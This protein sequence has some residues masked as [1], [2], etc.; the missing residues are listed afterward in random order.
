M[1]P[2][3]SRRISYSKKEM[4]DKR[5]QTHLGTA[6]L[7]YERKFVTP[8]FPG[9]VSQKTINDQD[10]FLDKL[11]SDT[12]QMG[13][14]QQKGTKDWQAIADHTSAMVAK[15]CKSITNKQRQNYLLFQGFINAMKSGKLEG[16]MEKDQIN[17]IIK[18]FGFF[19]QV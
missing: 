14:S 13:R 4:A 8:S 16:K 19:N 17:H 3:N 15:L 6:S 18:E 5:Q 1:N 7:N 9:Q 12:R 2:L 10:I 11:M